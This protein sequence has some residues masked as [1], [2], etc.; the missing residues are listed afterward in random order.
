M[1]FSIN[2]NVLVKVLEKIYHIAGSKAQPMLNNVLIDA[3]DN[4][5]KLTVSNWCNSANAKIYCEIIESGNACVNVIDLLSIIKTFD[6][7]I[8]IETRESTFILTENNIMVKLDAANPK[9]YPNETIN[10]KN[11]KSFVIKGNELIKSINKSIPFV[12]NEEKSVMC[13]LLFDVK[14]NILELW[15]CQNSSISK[16]RYALKGK[17]DEL[18]FIL[19]MK[20]AKELLKIIDDKD[21]LVETDNKKVKF[22]VDNIEYFSCLQNGNYPKVNTIAADNENVITFNRKELLKV[23]DRIKILKVKDYF[24]VAVTV[25]GFTA[26]FEYGTK[27]KEI[28][29]I[30]HCGENIAFAVNSNLFTS[31]IN[32]FDADEVSVKLNTAS[33]PILFEEGNQKLMLAPIVERFKQ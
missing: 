13:S 27:L 11:N 10:L 9:D 22:T 2:K 8:T 14:N 28:L 17:V 3:S 12:E 4:E 21:V 24:T 32:I 1:K 29:T 30:K 25:D 16:I 6:E 23:L 31:A 18:S 33:S 5:I 19:P 15:G 26:K 7:F 20:S